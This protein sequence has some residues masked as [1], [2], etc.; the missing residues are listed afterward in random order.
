M[1]IAT[2]ADGYIYLAEGSIMNTGDSTRYH[3]HH[4]T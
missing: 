2:D 3:L 4:V 1:V